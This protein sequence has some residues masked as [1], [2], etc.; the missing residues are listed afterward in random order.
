VENHFIETIH[1]GIEWVVLGIELLAVAVIVVAVFIV[2]VTRRTVRYLFQSDKQSL[3]EASKHQLSKA[4]LLG[5]ELMVA[6]DVVRTVALEP[7]L[8]NVAVLGLLVVVR[9][10]LSWS[11]LV[12]MEGHWPWR[13]KSQAAD[14][15]PGN[16]PTEGK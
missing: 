16:P 13:A 11:L 3:Y 8:T 10:L 6:A 15:G 5:L 9:T 12:E 7:T 14:S 2:A 1:Q 4:L